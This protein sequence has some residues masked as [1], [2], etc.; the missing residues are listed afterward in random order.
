MR[1]YT[2]LLIVLLAFFAGTTLWAQT[3]GRVEVGFNLGWTFS[4]GVSASSPVL[5]GDGNLYDRVD[6]K[7]SF[8]WGLTGEYLINPKMGIGFRFDQQQSKLDISGPAVTREIGDMKIQ[9]YHG[10]FTYRF[11]HEDAKAQPFIQAGIGATHFGSVSFTGLNGAQ[12]STGGQTK[13]S[14]TIGGGVKIY[15]TPKVGFQGIVNWTPTYI[16]SDS[17]GW[18]CDPFFGCYVVGSAQ[19]ANQFEMGGGVFFRF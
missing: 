1:K 8:S 12:L 18:W 10:I 16:K 9:N 14:G 4:D 15:A 3:E 17:A 5:A 7:D 19:Y 6:P 11:G 2:F 13:F